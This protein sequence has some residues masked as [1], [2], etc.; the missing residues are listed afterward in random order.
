MSTAILILRAVFSR[1]LSLIEYAVQNVAWDAKHA[2]PPLALHF[3]SA[4]VYHTR[5][6]AKLADHR[7]SADVKNSRD[8][9][10]SEV[11][12]FLHLRCSSLQEILRN[13]G[14][15]KLQSGLSSVD[16]AAFTGASFH[17]LFER[18]PEYVVKLL[19]PPLVPL[20]VVFRDDGHRVPKELSDFLNT[21]AFKQQFNGCG[22]AETMGMTIGESGGCEHFLE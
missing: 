7:I 9:R 16:T 1:D 11:F 17:S 21:H 5:L 15:R 10:D 14:N 12:N 2:V 19:L 20:R 22:I 3:G 13:A 4:E 6:V 8:L 18:S